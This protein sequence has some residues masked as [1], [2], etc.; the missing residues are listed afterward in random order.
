MGCTEKHRNPDIQAL[1]LCQGGEAF[2][3]DPTTAFPKWEK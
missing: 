1:A 3:T 2:G